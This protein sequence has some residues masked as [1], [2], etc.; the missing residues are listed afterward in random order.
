[1]NAECGSPVA[2]FVPRVRP[3]MNLTLDAQPSCSNGGADQKTGVVTL[4][5]IKFSNDTTVYTPN[6]SDYTYN[7]YFYRSKSLATNTFDGATTGD[8]SDA[9]NPQGADAF[10]FNGAQKGFYIVRVKDAN[11]GCY[12]KSEPVEVKLL[13]PVDF[14]VEIRQHYDCGDSNDVND[15]GTAAI[16]WVS[17]IPSNYDVI[18][19]DANN[20]EITRGRG[21]TVLSSLPAGSYSAT[22]TYKGST[23][24]CANT[25]QFKILPLTDITATSTETAVTCKGLYDGASTLE[26]THLDDVAAYDGGTNQDKFYAF[27]PNVKF[28]LTTSDQSVSDISAISKYVK[29]FSIEKSYNISVL[30]KDVRIKYTAQDSNTSDDIVTGQKLQTDKFEISGLPAGNYTI[31]F[32]YGDYSA[33]APYSYD[34]TITEPDNAINV[35]QTSVTDVSCNGAADGVIEVKT[36]I[37]GNVANAN[38]SNYTFEL[39]DGTISKG[40]NNTGKFEA[41]APSDKYTLTVSDAIGCSVTKNFHIFQPATLEIGNTSFSIDG[42]CRGKVETNA[43]GGWATVTDIKKNERRHTSTF[44]LQLFDENGVAVSNPE[45]VGNEEIHS[46][47]IDV[48]SL[49]KPQTYTVKAFTYWENNNSLVD[50]LHTTIADGRYTSPQTLQQFSCEETKDVTIYPQVVASIDKVDFLCADNQVDAS[51]KKSV[52]TITVGRLRW[53]IH[54]YLRPP[55]CFLRR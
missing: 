17:A 45:Q 13:D 34:F 50:S 48:A 36:M 38:L 14:K 6:T 12:Y 29:D 18:W 27:A 7:W 39:K 20:N 16:E 24:T 43:K 46:F 51:G 1:M 33:C 32:M 22:V 25:V 5:E 52:A 19:Y 23:T 49:T 47:T 4:T 28:Y 41:L 8:A 3:D 10:T 30:S 2:K 11:T 40:K 35:L 9:T 15:L 37:G 31:Y 54:S 42:N 26:F 44:F 55:N 53:S 21:N